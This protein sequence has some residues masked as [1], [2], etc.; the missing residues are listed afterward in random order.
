MA[1]V[2]ASILG[3]PS[4][5]GQR[6]RHGGGGGAVVAAPAP[7]AAAGSPA[8]PRRSVQPVVHGQPLGRAPQPPARE[9]NAPLPP[10]AA[11]EAA[12]PCVQA[13]WRA[14]RC[15][16][17]L[18]AGGGGGGGGG[19][20]RR[21]NT[22]DRAHAELQPRPVLAF[23]SRQQCSQRL[24]EWYKKLHVATLAKSQQPPEP[25]PPRPPPMPRGC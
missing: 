12:I 17:C 13:V 19:T 16:P 7:P 15:L 8:Q 3:P 21:V 25:Q 14:D 20:A 6:A 1:D 4:K 23:L 24:N 18:G 2:N 11:L 9:P 10:A 5:G 22:L